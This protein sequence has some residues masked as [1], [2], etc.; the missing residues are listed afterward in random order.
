MKDIGDQLKELENVQELKLLRKLKLLREE[1]DECYH[2]DAFTSTPMWIITRRHALVNLIDG[3]E[4]ELEK[5]D[6]K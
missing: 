2:D 1:L 3:V 4:K 5:I 6:Q